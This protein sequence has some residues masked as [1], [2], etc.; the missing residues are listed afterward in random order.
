MRGFVARTLPEL[1]L[2][3]GLV[4]IHMLLRIFLLC[5]V[6]ADANHLAFAQKTQQ[7]VNPSSQTSAPGNYGQTIFSSDTPGK[8]LPARSSSQPAA[9]PSPG[10]LISNDERAALTCRS[11]NL[12]VHLTPARHS[13]AVR[14]RMTVQNSSGRPLSRIALQLS[15]ALHWNTIRVNGNEATFQVEAVASDIDHT[16]ELTEAVV[17]LPAPIAPGAAASLDVLYSGKIELS[18]E[19]LLRLGAPEKIAASSEWDSIDSG[20]T[21]L[22]GFGNA[23]WFPVSTVPVLLGEG[24][25]MFDS[26]GKWKL[27][28]A[29]AKVS[30]RVLVEYTAEKPAVAFLNGAVISPDSSSPDKSPGETAE[31]SSDKTSLPNEIPRVASFT[32]PPEPL[33][34][35][36]LSLFV[37]DGSIQHFPGIDFYTRRG[38]EP[39]AAGYEKIASETR[40]LIEQWLGTREKHPVVLVDLPDSDD[41]PFETANA[42]FLPLHA[43]PSADQVGPVMAHML[44]HAYFLSQRPWLDEGMAQLMTLFWIEQQAG[45]A[46][47]IAEMDSHRAALAL[48]EPSDPGTNA[49][50]SLVNA[51]S[52]IYYRNK[53]ADVLWMLRDI[54]GDTA[55]SSALQAYDAAKDHEASYLQ[56]LLEKYSRKDLEWFFD[57]WVYRDRGLPDLT[58]ASAYSRPILT[59]NNAAKNYLVS[60]GVQ[61]DG[62]CSAEVPVTVESV[63]SSQTKRLLVPAHSHA[64]VRMLLDSKPVRAVVNDGSVPEVQTSHHEKAVSPAQ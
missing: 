50:Q 1:G 37:V 33:G 54:V 60:V 43:N 17:G 15:S 23:I 52:D 48:I 28:E 51:W 61:N 55:F 63:S 16:G 6:F 19:R 36:P 24:S 12:E 7:P 49:G 10:N 56:T 40:P 20:F 53:A 11:Y 4:H 25:E 46:A 38:N 45:R 13:I 29:S 62:F 5:A 59:K 3:S 27:R 22:R 31:P 64:D 35:S 39:L 9:S 30:M 58:I 34:F 2:K 42:L 18:S 57:D 8:N 26:V 44:G 47:A 14:A 41:L 21:A 32:L